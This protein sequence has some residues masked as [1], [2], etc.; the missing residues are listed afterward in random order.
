MAQCIKTTRTAIVVINNTSDNFCENN[1]QENMFTG[2]DRA[3]PRLLPGGP[4]LGVSLPLLLSL[5]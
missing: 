5:N 4:L 3:S 1:E 2:L